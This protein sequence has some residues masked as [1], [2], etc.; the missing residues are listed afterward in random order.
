MKKTTQDIV[1]ML[2]I[3]CYIS[4][5][6]KNE[7]SVLSA[8]STHQLSEI[9]NIIAMTSNHTY[10]VVDFKDYYAVS[11]NLNDNERA[12]VIPDCTSF[13]NL[14]SQL[15]MNSIMFNVKRICHIVY[16]T[17]TNKVAPDEQIHIENPFTERITL[18]RE[19]F[20]DSLQELSD[21]NGK[22]VSAIL[23][24]DSDD[25]RESISAICQ[26][27]YILSEMKN[28]NSIYRIYN[29]YIF[30]MSQTSE[31]ISFGPIEA[32]TFKKTLYNYIAHEN[33]NLSPIFLLR[34]LLQNGFGLIQLS[35]L[36]Y[37][38]PTRIKKYIDSNISCSMS[39]ADIS[40]NT[41]I[42]EKK[43]NAIFKK[44][45]NITIRQ[46]IINKRVAISKHL[47]LRTHLSLEE[48]S[49]TTGFNDKTHFIT[50]FKNHVQQTPALY[51][52]LN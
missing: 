6:V 20:I 38:Q 47:L 1:N 45:F 5:K 42:H 12:I 30:L 52:Q 37:D 27:A 19:E 33:S 10:Y 9:K 28:P 40:E 29:E 49:M 26:N 18:S 24:R 13:D 7:I 32:L 21:L 41:K 25:Y 8:K 15:N 31:L 16:E 11:I 4:H 51:R 2:G 23:K 34:K 14:E 48:I 22:F 3:E 50:T 36:N 46:Y 39:L 17:Y 43:L 35:N 44:A